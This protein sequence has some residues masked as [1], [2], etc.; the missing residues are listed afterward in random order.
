MTEQIE[1]LVQKVE[2]LKDREARQTAL[3]L[4]QAIMELHGAGLE[5]I[6]EL[7]AQAHEPLLD[8]FASDEKVEGLL[9]LYGLHPVDLEGRV[10]RALDRVR[11]TML[12]RNASA[13][14]LGI[15]NGAIRIRIDGANPFS[16]PELKA[17]LE[18]AVYAA[19]PDA[20][21]LVILG[22]PEP[23]SGFVPLSSLVAM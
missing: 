9:L 20:T 3:D 8:V 14:L 23:A 16:G 4:I 21:N 11:L 17:A 18:E 22:I 5:R 7:V 13:H 6:M 12:S 10:K 15:E 2:S 19:A 1:G